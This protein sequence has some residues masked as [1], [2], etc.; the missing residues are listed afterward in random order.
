MASARLE[1]FPWRYTTGAG[2]RPGAANEVHHKVDPAGYVIKVDRWP[3]PKPMPRRFP[4]KR[5][6]WGLA[7]HSSCARCCGCLA[8]K[9]VLTQS[10]RKLG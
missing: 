6:R 2:G 4:K 5:A 9:R 7:A 3:M 10:C 8:G 1:E